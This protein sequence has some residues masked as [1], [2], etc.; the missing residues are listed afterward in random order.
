L[1]IIDNTTGFSVRYI[2]WENIMKIKEYNL[3]FGLFGKF[4]VI[5]VDNPDEYIKHYKNRLF[6]ILA[7]MF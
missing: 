4:I 7:K 6:Q 1:G 2:K 5:I 3:L